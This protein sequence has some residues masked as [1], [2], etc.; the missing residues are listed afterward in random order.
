MK[1]YLFTILAATVA[2]VG[3]SKINPGNA[4]EE[5]DQL[6]QFDA[7]KYV[8]STKADAD[9]QGHKELE[10]SFAV[11][12]YYTGNYD[13]K[14]A[15]STTLANA[16]VYIQ[17]TSP[18]TGAT[19]TKNASGVWSAG[20]Y[21]WPK[22]GKLSFVGWV[23]ATL[24]PTF[25]TTD[26]TFMT[27]SYTV[28]DAKS[29]QADLLISD[30]TENKTIANADDHTHF[31]DGVPM[32]FHHTLSKIVIKAKAVNDDIDAIKHF[33]V[34]NSVTIAGQGTTNTYTLKRD[35]TGGWGDSATGT[36]EAATLCTYSNPASKTYGSNLAASDFATGALLP[37]GTTA[38][39]A[40][41][42]TLCDAYYVMP[43]DIDDA[44]T[45]TVKYTIY[46]CNASGMILD[47]LD[48]TSTGEAFQVNE[49]TKDSVAIDEWNDNTVYQYTIIVNPN[50][51][52]KKITFD[53]AVVDWSATEVDADDV[54]I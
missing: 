42:A 31:A 43:Q 49:F 28:P 4:V 6:I 7:Y 3:C 38:S 1:K 53:P 23:P 20:D 9:N 47:I 15:N 37:S 33:V 45:M 30:I 8:T 36:A 39:P 11:R 13:W 16:V 5:P 48:K 35:G 14:G 32:L 29:G 44:V 40:T 34:I 18:A 21:Y 51:S 12:A 17:G 2:I 26:N 10:T 22:T 50:S 27:L 19:V 25:S 54:T 52:T 41:A 24:A 46:Y